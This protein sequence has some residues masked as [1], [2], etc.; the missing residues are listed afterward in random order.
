MADTG[1][2]LAVRFP[3]GPSRGELLRIPICA[4]ELSRG[5][6]DSQGPGRSH[7]RTQLPASHA[8]PRGLAF[9]HDP[10]T[11]GLQ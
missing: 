10:E 1:Q 3:R 8:Q 7:V 2:E 5:A 9:F 11:D 4:M 6:P